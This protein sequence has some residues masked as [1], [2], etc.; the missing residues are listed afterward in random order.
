V[1]EVILNKRKYWEFLKDLYSRYNNDNLL[2]T[3]A[4]VTFFLLLSLFP[5][6]IFLINLISFTTI[7]NLKENIEVLKSLMPSNAYALFHD[8]I[9]QT[10]ANRSGTLLSF[11]MLF[12]LWSST[13]GI[14][15]VISGINRAYDQEETRPFWKV[16]IVSLF[17]TFELAIVII[18]SLILI[19]FGKILGTYLFHYFGFSASFLTIWNSV[20]LIIAFTT[21]IIVFISLY[22]TV[23]NRRISIKEA[24]P[25]SLFTSVGW[26]IISI[27]FSYYAN[28]F[29]NYRNLYGSLGGIIALLTWIYLSSIVILIGAEINAS[30]MF[31]K[32]GRKKEKAKRY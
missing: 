8:I 30:L 11:G 20:R 21:L 12:T 27:A 15:S 26:V 7:V 31:S 2:S 6:L 24:F 32:I 25:G 3:G 1:E 5:F 22:Y 23:P 10:V 4:Q 17:F 29:G 16:L 19:V 14:T 18:F 9:N 28:N 13:S